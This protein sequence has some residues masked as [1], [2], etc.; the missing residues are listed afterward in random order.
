MEKRDLTY[1][2]KCRGCSK[3]SEMY[4]GNTETTLPRDFIRWA[5]EH[6]TFPIER[7]CDCDRGSILF[8][9]IISYTIAAI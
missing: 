9:D 6:T 1:K 3:V 8:H 4:F 2:V 7:Q 5:N